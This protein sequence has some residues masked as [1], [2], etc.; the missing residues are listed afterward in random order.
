MTRTEVAAPGSVQV[1]KSSK[2]LVVLVVGRI[3]RHLGGPARTLE[4]YAQ[5]FTEHGYEV[6]ILAVGSPQVAHAM[7]RGKGIQVDVRSGPR[8]FTSG[9]AQLLQHRRPR[10]VIVFG[11]WHW[12]FFIS[13]AA[14]LFSKAFLRDRIRAVLVPTASLAPSDYRSHRLAKT[15]LSPIVQLCLTAFAKIAYSSTG[16][17]NASHP[18]VRKRKRLVQ[19]EP[20]PA[21][22][23]IRASFI[24]SGIDGDR[25]GACFIGRVSRVKS[26]EL[27]FSAMVSLPEAELAIL[28]SGE[29]AY[30]A[31]L[32]RLSMDLGIADRLHWAGWLDGDSVSDALMRTRVVVVTSHNENFCHAALE[33]VAGGARVLM[34]DRIM[35]ASDFSTIL[36]VSTCP[37]TP[38]AVAAGVRALLAE[39]D[40]DLGLRLGRSAIAAEKSNPASVVAQLIKSLALE[41]HEGV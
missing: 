18:R 2:G 28:G 31:S 39:P 41:S 9:F 6:R 20:S 40:A 15:L 38:A 16:E 29:S 27:L 30:V 33:A 24:A 34:V 8:Q 17:M 21:A 13:T 1:S 26:L 36:D 25:D 3:D 32:H 12:P 11:V 23:A 14:L 19:F 4:G 5:G 7:F 10:I 37:P 22:A 35:S